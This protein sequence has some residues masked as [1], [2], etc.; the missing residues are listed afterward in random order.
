MVLRCFVGAADVF[1]ELL[2]ANAVFARAAKRYSTR[3][4]LHP[5]TLL[6]SSCVLLLQERIEGRLLAHVFHG[7]R[8]QRQSKETCE[9]PDLR[10]EIGH[11]ILVKN[12]ENRSW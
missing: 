3:R 11:Q 5:R 2:F 1:L 6:Q 4:A 12:A 8:T 7:S 9:Q 10:F